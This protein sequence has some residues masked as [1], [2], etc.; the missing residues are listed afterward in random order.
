MDCEMIWDILKFPNF[1]YYLSASWVPT[2]TLTCR[3]IEYNHCMEWAIHRLYFSNRLGSIEGG[4]SG[5]LWC[6][7]LPVPL[8]CPGLPGSILD[9]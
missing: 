5:H 9:V 2:L 8:K 6:P 4:F 1:E 7:R 3:L